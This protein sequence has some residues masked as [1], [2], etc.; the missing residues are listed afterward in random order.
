VVFS[1]GGDVD[2][3]PPVLS[4]RYT[5]RSRR[6]S[7]ITLTPARKVMFPPAQPLARQVGRASKESG[8]D[9]QRHC[10]TEMQAYSAEIIFSSASKMC[11]SR[12]G[13]KASLRS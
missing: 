4:P 2:V 3:N 11:S 9:L 8:A 13:P 7:S 1:A 6:L 12:N 10:D 5:E